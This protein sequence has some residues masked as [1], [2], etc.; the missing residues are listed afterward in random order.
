M[1]VKVAGNVARDIR[2]T[3]LD[4]HDDL[5]SQGAEPV[6]RL[7]KMINER[8][9]T[10]DKQQHLYGTKSWCK[11]AAQEAYLC[12]VSR[13][14]SSRRRAFLNSAPIPATLV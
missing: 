3:A 2:N 9:I 7:E 6:A 14:R 13:W 12:D 4:K 8:Q 10:A 1:S 11:R 5:P